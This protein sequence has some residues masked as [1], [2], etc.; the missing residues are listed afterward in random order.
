MKLLL[1]LLC[2]ASSTVSFAYD[3]NAIND[4]IYVLHSRLLHEKGWTK[5]WESAAKTNYELRQDFEVKQHLKNILTTEND[6]IIIKENLSNTN[7]TCYTTIWRVGFEEKTSCNFSYRN[8]S[9]GQRH[10]EADRFT[11]NI[12][13]ERVCDEWESSLIGRVLG[14]IGSYDCDGYII[15]TR[16]ICRDQDD[17]SIDYIMYHK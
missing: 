3:W 7:H 2:F 13:L 9:T 17:Y 1:F 5:G 6:T 4:S 14:N 15:L 11:T 10:V 12:I 16:I 8:S